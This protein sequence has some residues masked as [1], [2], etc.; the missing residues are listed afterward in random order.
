MITRMDIYIENI[1]SPREQGIREG[2]RLQRVT[3][4]Q[5]RVYSVNFLNQMPVY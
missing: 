4:M 2:V 3:F 5:V 1:Y